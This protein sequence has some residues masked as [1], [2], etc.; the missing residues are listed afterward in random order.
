MSSGG[1]SPVQG[2][3]D[4]LQTKIAEVQ[5]SK[6]EVNQASKGV[7]ASI[8][9]SVGNFVSKTTSCIIDLFV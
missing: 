2:R 3:P 8:V 4:P 6:A 7:V 5:K 1:V 9:D